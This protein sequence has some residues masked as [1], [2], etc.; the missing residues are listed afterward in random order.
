M[1]RQ[2]IFVSYSHSDRIWLDR[3]LEHFAALERWKLLHAWTDGRIRVGESWEDEID[4]A[5]DEAKAAV[6]LVSPSFLAS[7]Y[8]W[9]EEMPR[10]KQHQA[11][12]MEVYPLILRACAWRLED[13]LQSL[14][15]RPV[16]GR[17]LALGSDAQID[18]DL[19]DFAFELAHLVG[20]VPG[21]LAARER[22]LADEFRG[23]ISGVRIPSRSANLFSDT[24]VPAVLEIVPQS[25]SGQ[26]FDG[27]QMTLT[28]SSWSDLAFQ[29]TLTYAEE[30]GTVTKVDGRLV[31]PESPADRADA[32]LVFTERGYID[33]GTRR[34]VDQGG[35]Y[36][37]TVT[38][39]V[40][41]GAWWKGDRRVADLRFELVR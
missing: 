19:T 25:W 23:M 37:V 4:R 32:N 2:K 8:I 17:P 21:A 41:H 6:L 16:D 10:I 30:T 9:R 38:G 39:T 40:M 11:D 1:P 36:R 35:E 15:A 27:E 13:A 26:Y 12:G 34:E 7:D 33:R 5:L 3:L 18:V 28:I 31:P 14:Q 24:A 22:E 20:R 29:G